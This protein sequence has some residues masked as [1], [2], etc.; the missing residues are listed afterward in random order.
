MAQNLHRHVACTQVIE[1]GLELRRRPVDQHGEP[2]LLRRR[3]GAGA[4][5]L[6]TY[7]VEHLAARRPA[8]NPEDT[9][10]LYR[11]L[12]AEAGA[13]PAVSVPQA[14]VWTDAL[15]RDDGAR[16]QWFVNATTAAAQ[17]RPELPTGAALTR[18]DGTPTG[19]LS[20]APLDVAVCRLSAG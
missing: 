13:L 8:A 19:T 18:I 6:S 10:R 14:D 9:W 7:P 2:A 12:A 1:R 15:E 4:V 20:L 11:A 5:V 3:V 17:V 16:F